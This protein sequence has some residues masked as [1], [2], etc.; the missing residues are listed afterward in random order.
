VKTGKW[1]GKWNPEL[2]GDTELLR[3]DADRFDLERVLH[4]GVDSPGCLRKFP[5]VHF[6]ARGFILLKKKTQTEYSSYG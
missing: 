6:R 5:F 1:A 2:L 4:G 3:P